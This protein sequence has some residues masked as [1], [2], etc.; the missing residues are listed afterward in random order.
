MLVFLYY[1]FYLG[2]NFAT[3]L[4]IQLT[5]TFIP[6]NHCMSIEKN[7]NNNNSTNNSDSE[8]VYLRVSI[9]Q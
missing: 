3:C 5:I 7:T 2:Q 4:S 1:L 8:N 9:Y 6:T